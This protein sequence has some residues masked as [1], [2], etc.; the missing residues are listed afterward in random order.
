M[1]KVQVG[2]LIVPTSSEGFSLAR[3]EGQH[4]IK[5][6]DSDYKYT[7]NYI[8][9]SSDLLR[10]HKYCWYYPDNFDYSHLDVT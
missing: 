10:T 2:W 5:E 6:D 1:H 7:L 4:C 8:T 3:G 9:F